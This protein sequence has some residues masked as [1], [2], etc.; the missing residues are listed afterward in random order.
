MRVEPLEELDCSVTDDR[1]RSE[2]RS[3][4]RLA[5]R[6]VVFWGNH[7]S[8]DHEDV[9]ATPVPQRLLE[10]RNQCEVARREQ[11]EFVKSESYKNNVI[12]W[13]NKYKTIPVLELPIDHPRVNPRTYNASRYDYLLSN[14]IVNA[15]KLTGVKQG[16][17]FVNTLLAA[18]EIFISGVSG[19][20]E[21]VVGLP[22]ADQSASGNYNL[23]GHCVNLLPIKSFIDTELNFEEYLKERKSAILDAYDHQ[24]FTFGSLLKTL[25]IK[26]DPSRVPLVPVVFN[27]DME[28]D[29]GVTFHNL[30]YSIISNPKQFRNFELSLNLWG[31]EKAMQ[32]EWSYNS[33]IFNR[34]T[35]VNMMVGFEN[36]LQSIVKDPTIANFIRRVVTLRPDERLA[37]VLNGDV[38]D[39]LAEDIAG[40]VAVDEAES[41]LLRIMGYASF[42]PVWDALAEFVHADKRTLVFVIGNHDIEI[43]FPSV[44]RLIIERLSA[45]NDAAK[46]RIEFS[47][48]GAGF[49]CMVGNAR[50]FCT[51][52][53]EVDPWNF[54]RYE[55]LSRVARRLNAGLTLSRDEWTPNAGTRMVK[56]VMNEVKKRYA[57]IDLLK[58]ETSAAMKRC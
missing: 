41:T 52:G 26:R 50:V 35:I 22:A 1:P 54:N 32:L 28:M 29:K 31:S 24:Q 42:V 10:L 58:P 2:D 23:V 39:T 9:V 43:A 25:K 40:Y 34:E 15:L 53:N 17:S 12:Y 46:A 21:I 33:D 3:G 48:L 44:Q 5:K 36:L 7:A 16:C 38:I 13:V 45:G 55:D 4:P 18:F 14:D 47:A 8:D 49:A 20:D 19:Q 6:V 51:H 57:W 37:L 11:V 30:E 56:D 27:I